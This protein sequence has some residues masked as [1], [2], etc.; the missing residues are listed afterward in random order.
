MEGAYV[1]NPNPG[2]YHDIVSFDA[3]SMYPR[4][5]MEY[6][7]SPET[8]VGVKP[9]ITVEVLMDRAYS[10]GEL[11]EQNVS[12]AAN[13]AMFSRSKR[14][15]L[16]SVV[17]KVFEERLYYKKK[18]LAA[19]AEF[20][21]KH[22]KKLAIDISR[23]KNIQKAKKTQLVSLYGATANKYFRYYDDRIAE[24]ITLTGQFYIRSVSKA[25]DGYLLDTHRKL[26]KTPDAGCTRWV[27]YND[28]DSCYVSLKPLMDVLFSVRN[29]PTDFYI[30]AMDDICQ[31]KL[32][33]VIT[34][35]CR[36]LA[37]DTNAFES[38]F[39]F[40]RE[41]LADV[42]LWTVKKRYAVQV[43]DKEGIRYLTPV[44]KVTGLET[45]RSSTPE[46]V[47]A[48][49]KA[50][51]NICLTGTEEQLQ[52]YIAEFEREFRTLPPEAIAFPRSVNGLS[53]YGSPATI[54]TKGTPM[55]VRA[56]LLYNH[57]IRLKELD[58]LHEKIQEGDKIKFLYLREPNTIG[59]NCF[60]FPIRLP[61]ELDIHR[62]IDYTTQFQKTFVDPIV[63][64]VSCLNWSV[65]PQA[66][67]ASLF[68]D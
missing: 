58:K 35:E 60:A 61:K 34:K 49:L 8:V 32:S 46:V 62:Y 9:N 28:T 14:G 22:D 67:L 55:H 25:L 18:Q 57:W 4:L 66:S 36:K 53:K 2:R 56:S 7:M 5:F 29:K 65:T 63:N 6:N 26:L 19:E 20:E 11:R 10:I 38:Q 27:F 17:H 3:T 43:W 16:P 39:E 52:N 24:A 51:L 31:K 64:I 30:S 21:K 59:E 1:W 41:I 68:G 44:L 12:L 15:I 33:P 37:Q 48:K 54:Y 47:R 50:I 23:Y 42:G 13:G 45:Q 40:K